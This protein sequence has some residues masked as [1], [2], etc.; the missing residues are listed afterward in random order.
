MFDILINKM[1][2][3]YSSLEND[4]GEMLICFNPE[5]KMLITKY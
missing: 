1:S 2:L 4:I 3:S 5:F